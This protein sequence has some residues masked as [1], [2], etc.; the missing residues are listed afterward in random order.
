MYTKQSKKLIIIN[1]LDILK[2]YTDED[3]RISQKE[4]MDILEQEYGMKVE[5]KTV[6][7]NLMNLIDFGYLVE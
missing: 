3:H 4:I 1:I 5:R 7:R 6:K 2:K